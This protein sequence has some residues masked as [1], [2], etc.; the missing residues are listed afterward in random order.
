MPLM[1]RGAGFAAA[2]L[3][4]MTI[5]P[6]LMP[7]AHAAISDNFND[8]A[9]GLQWSV[10]EDQPGQLDLIE[11]NQRLELIATDPAQPY[12]DAIY[13]SSGPAGF[14]LST[15]ADF[16]I[17]IDYNFTDPTGDG[18]VGEALALVFGVGRDPDGTDSAAVGM[19]WGTT[20]FLGSPVTGPAALVAYRTDDSAAEGDRLLFAPTSG[21]FEVLYDALGDD[22]TL[23]LQGQSFSYTLQDT[24]RAVWGAN[25]LLAS[26]GGRGEGFT[27]VSGEAWLDNFT[28]VTGQTLPIPEPASLALLSLGAAIGLTRR[29]PHTRA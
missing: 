27:T 23:G 29:R 22:L 2:I 6:T 14:R 21:T 13:L 19:G 10:I 7:A 16:H 24:V 1:R 18:G 26:F 15:A 25:S 5:E 11:Q 3:F 17:T 9:P 12:Y 20:E 8:N 28:L 4:A